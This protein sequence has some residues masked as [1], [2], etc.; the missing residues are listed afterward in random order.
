MHCSTNAI[1]GP[2]FLK[3][4]GCKRVSKIVCLVF[5][6]TALPFDTAIK[7]FYMFISNLGVNHLRFVHWIMFL[8]TDTILY[9]KVVQVLTKQSLRDGIMQASPLSQTSCLE[10]FHSVVNHFAP[11]MIAYSYSGQYCRY[12]KKSQ[13]SADSK[14][15][16][17]I[18]L[19]K[20][21]F[22]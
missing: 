10:G 2:T 6:C 21:L 9:E 8:L 11:K 22:Y 20:F 3:G 15:V 16:I 4:N 7:H 17:L 1:M 18:K 13:N 12:R 19:I 14:H 5:L